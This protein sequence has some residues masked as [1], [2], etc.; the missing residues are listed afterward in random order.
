MCVGTAVVWDLWTLL[1][2]KKGLT[3]R[4][5]I[6]HF[7]ARLLG[8]IVY[9]FALYLFWFYLHFE[10]LNK[11]GPGDSFMSADFQETLGDSPLARDAKEVQYHDIITIK[12]KDTGCLLHSH[13]Y[14]Y[15]LRY[16]DGRISSQGQQV[17]CMHDFT[18]TNNHWEILPPT[19]VGDSKVLGRVV[20]QGDTFRLRHV[21]TNGYLLTHDVASPLY[22]TNEEFQVIE[23]EAGDA[24][25]FN[26]TLFRLD[27]F[28]KRKESPLKTKASVVKVFH[29][30]TIVTMWTHNDELLPD[31]GFNQQE[32][33][34]S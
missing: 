24:A 30:P 7:Y 15:P 14:T 27:P 33:N 11:S 21:N 2:L 28:D 17:T 25:R 16:D 18:D 6:K 19:S 31:W 5:F 23:P 13:P 3:I 34:A 10:I 12:H 32:V 8:L 4:I 29:V 22:P 20:K 26:D 1:D 9:P